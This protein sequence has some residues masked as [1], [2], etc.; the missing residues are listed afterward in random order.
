[1]EEMNDKRYDW[2]K[3]YNKETHR[4]A[5]AKYDKEN[6]RSVGLKFHIKNE[7]DIL[8]R[9]DT[10]KPS[11][12]GYIKRL[13]REDIDRTGWKPAPKPVQSGDSEAEARKLFGM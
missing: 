9:L 10:A 2:R 3:Y 12:M 6:I 5:Q 1:M 4:A 7:A 13:I 8:E 11:K